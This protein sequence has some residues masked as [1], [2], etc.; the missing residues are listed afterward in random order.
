MPPPTLNASTLMPSTP[1]S[2]VPA[3]ANTRHTTAGEAIALNDMR[4]AVGVVRA[5]GEPREHGQQRQRLD[6][7]Q[8]DNEEFDQFVE[9]WQFADSAT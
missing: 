2:A 3:A 9:H 1:S 7:H 8:Q 5:F 4:A 6:D